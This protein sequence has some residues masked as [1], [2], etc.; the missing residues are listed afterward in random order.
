MTDDQEFWDDMTAHAQ[1][2]PRTIHGPPTGLD[3]S[4]MSREKI[5]AHYKAEL[6]GTAPWLVKDWSPRVVLPPLW[7]FEDLT[8]TTGTYLA[9]TLKLKAMLSCVRYEDNREWL[10]LSVSHRS[11]IPKWTELAE[12]KRVFLGDRE[13]YVVMPPRERYVNI[14]AYVLHVFALRDEKQAALP[15]FTM[16]CGSL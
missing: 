1:P 5:N 9:P 16:G 10:H 11:R 12:A 3:I 2:D 14:N 6:D 8:D 13:G 15:D 7:I 4:G